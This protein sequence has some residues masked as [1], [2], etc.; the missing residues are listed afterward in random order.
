MAGRKEARYE[1]YWEWRGTTNWRKKNDGALGG[2]VI[3]ELTGELKK[4]R[5]WKELNKWSKAWI[6]WLILIFW[7]IEMAGIFITFRFFRPVNKCQF[8]VNHKWKINFRPFGP[9]EG[10]GHVSLNFGHTLHPIPP[11]Q[12]HMCYLDE[13]RPFHFKHPKWGMP[14]TF[15]GNEGKWVCVWGRV[16]KKGWMI[17]KRKWIKKSSWHR[18]ENGGFWWIPLGIKGRG[19]WSSAL[20]YWKMLN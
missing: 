1:I 20:F 19:K 11:S 13:L 14:C 12:C 17:K 3:N 18:W 9:I 7:Q 15:T 2:M 4:G 10:W 16:R 8:S 5:I 6:H